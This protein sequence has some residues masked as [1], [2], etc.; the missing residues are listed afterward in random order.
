MSRTRK[1][2][3][4]K[5]PKFNSWE[6]LFRFLSVL[7][8]TGWLAALLEKLLLVFQESAARLRKSLLPVL[9][10][11]AAA[12]ACGVCADAFGAER[13]VLSGDFERGERNIQENL[14]ESGEDMDE[15]AFLDSNSDGGYVFNRGYL[16]LSKASEKGTVASLKYLYSDRNYYRENDRKFNRQAHG[17]SMTYLN[18]LSDSISLKLTLERRLQ[19]FG[20]NPAADND[21][22]KVGGEFKYSI[23]KKHLLIL[24]Y[25]DRCLE[26]NAD[27]SRTV[28][29]RV[30]EACLKRKA[31]FLEVSLRYRVKMT[32]YISETATRKDSVR[33]SALLNFSWKIK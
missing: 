3:S 11:L 9:I 7:K 1:S 4:R 19:K 15:A 23:G 20:A 18:S 12:G 29:V 25:D 27:R 28:Y 13:A 31:G 22:V 32:D 8:R 16:K 2:S 14:F 10:F 6:F 30:A 5:A 24:E 21:A 33:H 26:L 17:F